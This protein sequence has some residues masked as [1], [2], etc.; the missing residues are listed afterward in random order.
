MKRE[1]TATL[2][3][4][5]P[6][7]KERAS[8]IAER[9]YATLLTEHPELRPMFGADAQESGLQA[10]RLAK[11]I[12]AYVANLE[13]LDLL[14]PAIAR[15]SVRHVQVGVKPDQYPLVGEHLLRAIR[16]EL[17][18]AATPDLLGAWQDAYQQLAD[19]MIDAERRLYEPAVPAEPPLHP[20]PHRSS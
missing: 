1:S 11:A 4:A 13:R 16:A 19:I 7:L 17:A 14:S 9:F 12:L 3:S 18:A 6:L 10:A 8:A 15:I 20:L 5:L 2:Q